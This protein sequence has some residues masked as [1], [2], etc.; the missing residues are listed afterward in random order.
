MEAMV[1]MLAGVGEGGAMVVGSDMGIWE[2]GSGISRRTRPAGPMH[3][4]ADDAELK[5]H[6]L[7]FVKCLTQPR[8]GAGNARTR[9]AGD[10]NPNRRPHR[11]KYM[12]SNAIKK[13]PPEKNKN[14]N[15]R[16]KNKFSHKRA[17]ISK[18][19]P[20][21]KKG[22]KPPGAGILASDLSIPGAA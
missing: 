14:K 18:S 8:G 21:T 6:T 2:Q 1:A 7:N 10:M 9:A 12:I 4:R 13:H 17:C 19:N 3:P 22:H 20:L 5:T 16:P 15:A 11:Y